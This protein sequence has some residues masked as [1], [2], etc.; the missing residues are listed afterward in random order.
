M[1]EHEPTQFP[2]ADFLTTTQIQRS[3]PKNRLTSESIDFDPELCAVLDSF[4]EMR[5]QYITA[6][7]DYV[8]NPFSTEN[9][10]AQFPTEVII[11]QKAMDFIRFC[12][13]DSS[14]LPYVIPYKTLHLIAASIQNPK[15]LADIPT[16]QMVK[17]AL[18]VLNVTTQQQHMLIFMDTIALQIEK[19]TEEDQ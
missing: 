9:R 14:D 5:D 17:K 19:A 7:A 2:I 10:L 13:E 18:E 1:G 4:P 16:V 12:R 15:E 3:E 8:Q 6:Y 11:A